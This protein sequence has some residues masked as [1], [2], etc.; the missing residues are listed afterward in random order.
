MNEKVKHSVIILK[1]EIKGRS[2]NNKS[3]CHVTNT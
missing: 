3:L 1:K 2:K